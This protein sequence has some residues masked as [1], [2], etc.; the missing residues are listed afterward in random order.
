M[1]FSFSP[2]QIAPQGSQAAAAPGTVAPG[3]VASP[4]AGPPS[5]SPFL[6]IRERGKDLSIATCVQIVAIVTALLMTVTTAVMLS[7]SVYLKSSIDSKKAELETKEAQFKSYPFDDMRTLS[8]RLSALS[9]LLKLYISPRS[10]LKF[11]ENVVENNVVFNNFALE[12]SLTGTG[13]VIKFAIITNNYKS[14]IQQLQSLNLREYNK[15]TPTP[16]ADGFKDTDVEVQIN[17]S[18]PI[19]VQGLLPDE[20]IFLPPQSAP[21]KVLEASSTTP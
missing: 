13:Y 17:V 5:D 12:Q 4:V 11:L 21:T 16:V 15:I 19:F 9:A 10:P 20:L 6:F 2:G 3:A 7:Y 1:A 8:T 14:I 18:T